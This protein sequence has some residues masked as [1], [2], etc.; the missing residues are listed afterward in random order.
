M[1]LIRLAGMLWTGGSEEDWNVG[2][3]FEEGDSIDCEDGQ[4]ET[5]WQR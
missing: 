2:I 4:S 1:Q 3:E 5:D